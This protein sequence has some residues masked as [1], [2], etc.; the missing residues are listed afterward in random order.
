MESLKKE[1]IKNI[2]LTAMEKFDTRKKSTTF[3][4]SIK[5]DKCVLGNWGESSNEIYFLVKN[6]PSFKLFKKN[7]YIYYSGKSDD[8]FFI[9]EDSKIKELVLFFFN[10]VSNRIITEA[11]LSNRISSVNG[12]GYGIGKI[13]KNIFIQL[14]FAFQ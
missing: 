4:F 7:E 6:T 9:V 14:L 2:T 8:S 1:L 3:K 13:T 5:E 11:N 10:Q 12:S